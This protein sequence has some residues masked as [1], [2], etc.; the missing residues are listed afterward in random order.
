MSDLSKK[1]TQ[2]YIFVVVLLCMVALAII[3]KVGYIMTMQRDFGQRKLDSLKVDSM[4]ELP[5]RGRILSSDGQLLAS[6]LPEYKIFLDYKVGGKK[7]DSILVEKMDSICEGLHKIFPNRSAEDFRKHLEAGREAKSQNWPIY[8]NVRKDGKFSP[9]AISYT[10]YKEV[11]QLPVFNMPRLRGGFITE[12]LPNRRKWPFGSLA[13]RTLGSTTAEKD[14]ATSGLE[15]AF[16]SIL[17]GKVGYYHKQRVRNKTLKMI[18]V[19]PTNGNDIVTTIDVSMQDICEKALRE[20]MNDETIR[21]YAGTVILM[22]VATGDIK[23]IVNMDRADDGTLYEGTPHGISDL[24]EPGSTFKTASIMVALDDGVVDLGFTV[25]TGSG[26]VTMHGQPMRDHNYRTGGC[27]VIDVPHVLMKSSNIGTS[28]IIDGFYAKDP[29]KYV[30]GLHRIGIAEDLKLPLREY[31]APR[32]RRPNPKNWWKTTLAWMSIGYETQIA[33]IN[34]LAFYNAIANDGK[35]MRP[36]F[37]KHVEKDGE[38]LQTFQPEVMKEQICKPETLDKMRKILRRVVAE[39]VGKKA[40]THQFEVA[41]KTGTAQVA[42]ARGYNKGGLMHYLVSFCGYF[43]ANAPKYTC[44]VAMRKAGSP[45]SGGSQCGPVFRAIAERIYARDLTKTLEEARDTLHSHTPEVK[46]GDVKAADHLLE[47]LSVKSSK[48]WEKKND[49]APVWG[50]AKKE[51]REV[52]LTEQSRN[53]EKVP[54]VIGMGAK[55]AVFLLEEAGLKV[56]V[57]GTGKVTQQSIAAGN[58]VVKGET[59]NITLK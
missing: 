42:G 14:S 5:V 46:A 2:R 23:A 16:D 47:N 38:I 55:D 32:I 13:R 19:P 41:G 18:D 7:K 6:S 37:V 34:T 15:L 53:K 56:Q 29:N 20:Q 33:P 27:G 17:R 36:R 11:E 51:G 57:K 4:T 50:T 43:P 48:S 10:Q 12:K 54:N 59:I 26:I 8:A 52:I 35:M 31:M 24:M 28:K 45:A 22:E 21:A 40:G 3:G 58:N 9:I 1:I 39:G 30:D 25:N 49:N 44:I